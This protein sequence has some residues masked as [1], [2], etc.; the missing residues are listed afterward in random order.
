MKFELILTHAHT[1]T[2]GLRSLWIVIATMIQ[3]LDRMIT[4]TDYSTPFQL[5]VRLTS[6]PFSFPPSLPSHHFPSSPII[7]SFSQTK[8]KTKTRTTK[9]NLHKQDPRTRQPPSTYC[10]LNPSVLHP[11]PLDYPYDALEPHISKEIMTLHHTKHHQ[12]YVNGLNSAEEAYAKTES[13]KQRIRLQ[14]ALKFNGGGAWLSLPSTTTE[15]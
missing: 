11:S 2:A 13:P 4:P 5:Q 10:I 6:L 8:T 14:A 1:L 3:D 15:C 12:T 7:S 9:F